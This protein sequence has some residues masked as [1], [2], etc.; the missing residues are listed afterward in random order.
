[1]EL[2]FDQDQLQQNALRY[3]RRYQELEK[4]YKLLQT[5][6]SSSA[7]GGGGTI[8]ANATASG[9]TGAGGGHLLGAT[10]G[11]TTGPG[12]TNSILTREE[13]R[14]L[15]TPV[16]L[17]GTPSAPIGTTSRLLPGSQGMMH[18]SSKREMELESVIE[19][20]KRV[21][22]KFRQENERLK[23]GIGTPSRPPMPGEEDTVTATGGS[24]NRNN[25]KVSIV[26]FE[27]KFQQEKKKVEKLEEEKVGL[28]KKFKDTE[29][30]S[31]K[32]VMRQQQITTLKKQLASKEEEYMKIQAQL[33][34]T[35][36]TNEQLTR[37]QKSL[38]DQ[39]TNLNLTMKQMQQQISSL[40]Q[41]KQ[42][43]QQQQMMQSQPAA[44]PMNQ[45]N[46]NNAMGLR[47]ENETL[48]R[49]LLQQTTDLQLLQ[50]EIQELRKKSNTFGAS[51][52]G[53][54]GGGGTVGKQDFDRLKEENR[55][56]KEELSAF[57]LDFFEEIENLKYAHAEALRKLRMYEGG[58]GGGGG[59]GRSISPGGYTTGGRSVSR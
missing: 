46:N 38:E 35:Y 44:V 39:I 51:S 36:Q 30:L 5:M 42:Q 40:Q 20:M 28:Q 41:E 13:D 56:L 22:D 12:G 58:G 43:L 7:S 11:Q 16:H 53:P 18:N 9:M 25:N 57:D 55:K 47:K 2:Q 50:Q 34:T 31:A 45:Q 24:S 23:R 6:A 48:Q 54:S 14:L 49:Q 17:L 33:T 37:S 10:M 8:S 26:D 3:Q 27:K 19:S 4:S 52:T 15:A 1:M 59:R 29:D 32:V 21:I